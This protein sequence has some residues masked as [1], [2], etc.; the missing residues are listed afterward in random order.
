LSLGAFFT[1]VSSLLPYTM[2]H[3]EEEKVSSAQGHRY[4]LPR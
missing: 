2:I 3:A 1:V 4:E